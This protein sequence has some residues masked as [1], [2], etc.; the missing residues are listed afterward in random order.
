MNFNELDRTL[1]NGFH[2]AK[3]RHFEMDYVNRTLR[4]ELAVWIG[5]MADAQARE[6]Y[7][8]AQV[9]VAGVAFLVIE[10]PD[11]NYPWLKAGAVCID[12]G[13]GL[14]KQSSS[15]VPVAPKGT[16]TTWVYFREMNRFL[17]FAG[18]EASLEWTGPVENWK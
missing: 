4:F 5:K 10:P 17:L 13:E 2:D 8:P 15:K 1:P 16:E 12:T 6:L 7:R 14:P 18:G 11:T 3:L 9:N